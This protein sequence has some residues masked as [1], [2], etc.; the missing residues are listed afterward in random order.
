M[1]AIRVEVRRLCRAVLDGDVEVQT[2]AQRLKE[3]TRHARHEDLSLAISCTLFALWD[4]SMESDTE[5]SQRPSRVARLAQELCQN[6][7]LNEDVWLS[8]TDWDL[9]DASK[10]V[11]SV[12]NERR[13]EVRFYTRVVYVQTRYNLFSECP[14]GFAR[15]FSLLQRPT[16][17]N[18]DALRHE[19]CRLVGALK[20]EPHR[21]LD[22]LLEF[23]PPQTHPSHRLLS[24]FDPQKTAH[25]LG[26]KIQQSLAVANKEATETE[27]EQRADKLPRTTRIGKGEDLRVAKEQSVATK[28]AGGGGGGGSDRRMARR[29]FR[30]CAALEVQGLVDVSIVFRYF[31]LTLDETRAKAQAFVQSLR[32]AAKLQ[33]RPNL[34]APLP[35]ERSRMT[36]KDKD[37]HSV[38]RDPKKFSYQPHTVLQL[39]AAAPTADD[40]YLRL[41]AGFLETTQPG[42]ALR[43]MRAVGD[44]FCS[45]VKEGCLGVVERLVDPFFRRI[46]ASARSIERFLDDVKSPLFPCLRIA[47]PAVFEWLSVAGYHLHHSLDLFRKTVFVMAHELRFYGH[48]SYSAASMTRFPPPAAHTAERMIS[49]VFLPALLLMEQKTGLLAAAWIDGLIKLCSYSVRIMIGIH[50]EEVVEKTAFLDRCVAMAE[51]AARHLIKLLTTA[52]NS[53]LFEKRVIPTVDALGRIAISAPYHV[54]TL[55]GTI[56]VM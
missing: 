11:A 32:D 14:T 36:E 41:A 39:E 21:V 33:R 22:T 12:E 8:T 28:S 49:A 44:V 48:P 43:I 45:D 50:F 46:S 25:V 16:L 54:R 31:P 2:A 1:R 7:T 37:V 15:L 40:P 20:I 3:L 10:T 17:K 18:V 52:Q 34:G 35:D 30:L 24:L 9:L 51:T 13:R 29:Y 53:E 26:R 5:T 56:G 47:A 38:H 4:L 27:I 19:L 42:R 55:F 6:G 23:L